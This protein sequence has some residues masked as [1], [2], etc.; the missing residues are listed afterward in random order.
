LSAQDP[1]PALSPDAQ[2]LLSPW[3][4]PCGGLPPYDRATPAAL[5]EALPQAVAE[6][7]RA[8]RAIADNA[9]PPTFIN[10]VAAL[11]SSARVLR[12][13]HALAMSVATTASVGDMPAVAQRL[14]PLVPALELEIAHDRALF[15]RVEAVWQARHETGLDAQ[16]QRLVEVLHRRLLRAGA[17]LGDTE[18]AQLKAID[19]RIA[20]LQSR[21]NQNLLAEQAAQVTWFTDAAL[22]DG[23]PPGQQQVA[24]ETARALGRAGTWAI[25]NQRPAV[26][27]FLQHVTRRDSR[28]A[29]WRLW[30]GRGGHDGP[31]DN[32][33]LIAEMLQLR[34]ER[35]RLLGAASHAH[36]VLADRMAGTPAAALALMHKTWE[37]VLAATQRQVADYQALADA[38]AD[39][40]G[41]PRYALAP[42]DRLYL[43]EGLRR[44][45]FNVDGEQL[46]QYLPLERMLEALFWAAGRVHGLAFAALPGAPVLHPSVR[47]FEV[48]RD[49]EAIGVLYLDL[50]QRPG[51][52]HGSHQ[53]R[54]RAAEHFEHRVLPISSIVS[55][56]P[57]PQ[58]G[59][60]ALLPWEYA[61]VLFHEFGHA[62]H[63][64]LD[65]T[66]YPSL[67]SLA[68]A[69]D[70]VE[71]PSLLN[72][73][74]L[75][76]RELMHRFARH[77]ATGEPMPDAMLDRLEASLQ[78]DRIFSVNLDYL[79]AAIVDMELHLLADG[80]GR[81]ID[82]VA[83]EQ[84]TLQ[85]LGM[86]VCWDL[87]LYAT[88]SVHC[89]A[90]A[91][92]AGL[93]SYLWSDV[94]AADVAEQFLHSAGGLY[95]APT[96]K[97]WHDRV[98]SVG[99]SVPADAAFQALRGRDTDPTALM[100]R[101]GLAP[102]RSARGEGTTGTL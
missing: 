28:E 45:R 14:A 60:P 55:G 88:H 49:D 77:H 17:A 9:E 20:V 83:V 37:P 85:A 39:A 35:A 26:W 61:N 41:Q 25:P 38:E 94:M 69:W 53:H 40:A 101:F 86:P 3:P 91:Y 44:Q 27:P 5:A 22:L 68:V 62:L 21:F 54:L 15:A 2:A 43:A 96:A 76:D 87:V 89:F 81:D 100:R 46:M 72:E 24:A 99:H 70:L 80:N 29:V 32:R 18:Q 4:G 71:L 84:R 65:G 64:L 7:R 31:H 1:C 51:K 19:A 75:R 52:M 56:V 50:F 34:G 92:D 42:W 33:P 82:A 13:V 23:L 78:H 47:V 59:Q 11:E 98:L 12:D 102:A 67:G 16:Q 79:G 97:T 90:G 74:W 58:E 57:A 66:R 73:Y 6:R 10:T 30:A 36:W 63:M 95:D 93:Y 48:R 8:V